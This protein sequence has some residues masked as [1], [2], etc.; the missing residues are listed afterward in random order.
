MS[1][2]LADADERFGGVSSRSSIDTELAEF[3][4]RNRILALVDDDAVEIG[5]GRDDVVDEDDRK[6]ESAV[7]AWAEAREDVVPATGFEGSRV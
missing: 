7:E 1:S 6:E 2:T 4:L 3:D 5:F